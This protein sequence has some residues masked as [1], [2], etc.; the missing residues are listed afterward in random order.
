MPF[1][2]DAIDRLNPRLSASA[3]TLLR[4]ARRDHHLLLD[5]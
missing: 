1:T 3:L 4:L 2:D 5:N